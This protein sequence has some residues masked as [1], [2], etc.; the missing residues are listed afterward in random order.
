ML[1][2]FQELAV[3]GNV[4]DLAV[5][6]VIGAAFGGIVSS[7]VGDFF[8]PIIGAI[9]SGRDFSNYLIALPPKVAADTLA[10]AKE[11][12]ACWRGAISSPSSSTS[13]LSRAYFSGWSIRSS[14]SGKWT[15]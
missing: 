13:S 2:N 3:K 4:F 7:L 8:M 14:T 6:L 11:Q 12:G 15:P 5:G 9:T 1:E 10:E